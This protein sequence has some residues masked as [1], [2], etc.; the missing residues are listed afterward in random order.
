MVDEISLQ[1][2]VVFWI[3]APLCLFA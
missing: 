3:C 1:S 2:L